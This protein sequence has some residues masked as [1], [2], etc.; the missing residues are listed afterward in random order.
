MCSHLELALYSTT[1]LLQELLRW[2]LETIGLLSR[3]YTQEGRQNLE[4]MFNGVKNLLDNEV[5][6]HAL[7]TVYKHVYF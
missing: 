1:T 2:V 3:V 5:K 7:K 4:K 6:K